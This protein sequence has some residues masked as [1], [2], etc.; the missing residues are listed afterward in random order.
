MKPLVLP[1]GGTWTDARRLLVKLEQGQALVYHEGFLLCDRKSFRVA[2][3]A[4]YILEEG[5]PENFRYA[6]GWSDLVVNGR[7]RGHLTQVRLEKG[8][9]RYLFT[10]R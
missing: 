6:E 7:N 5:T 3:I 2:Q 10:R 8:G 4:D 1:P 9:F